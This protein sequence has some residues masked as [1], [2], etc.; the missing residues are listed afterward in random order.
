MNTTKCTTK[1]VSHW[2]GWLVLL[3]FPII[4][5][6]H[7]HMDKSQ[8]AKGEVLAAA[9]T[10]VQLWFSGGVSAEWSKIEVANAKGERVDSGAVST[11]GDDAKSLQIKLKP[12][13]PGSYEIRWNAVSNDGHRVK[14]SSPFT[15]K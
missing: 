13:G 6:A 1:R 2:A 12:I 4:S 14:G 8:P 9:P 11:I 15:V 7:V 10:V 5:H 3:L